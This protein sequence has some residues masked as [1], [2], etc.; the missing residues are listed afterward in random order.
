[1]IIDWLVIFLYLIGITLIGIRAAK[2]VKVASTFFISDRQCG[3]IMIMFFSFGTGTHTDVA[4]GVAGKTHESG[5]SGI[6]YQW[7]WL[8]STPFYWLLAPL[9]R[10]MRAVTTADYFFKRYGRSVEVLFALVGMAQLT[11]SIG[12][13]LK[14]SSAMITAVSG[15]AISPALAIGAMT[16]LFVIYGVAGGLHAAIITDFIQGLLAIV[17]SFLIL[18]F[19]LNAVGGLEGLRTMIDV[20]SIFSIVA[21]G[22]ITTFYIIIISLNGLIGWVTAPYSMTMCARQN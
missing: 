2:K 8:F 13:M 16:V 3:K 21:P 11:V 12:L 5:A 19:A 22:E 14:G 6:W 4:V 10:R 18:P 20:P 7:L 9:F 17:L 15:G 1:M